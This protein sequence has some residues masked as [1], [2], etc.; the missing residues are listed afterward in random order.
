VKKNEKEHY[1]NNRDFSNAVVEHVT[2]VNEAIA[3]ESDIPR[4]TNYIATCFMKISE[5]LSH[6]SNFIRYSYRDEMVMD[7]VENCLKAIK[8]YNVEAA[9]RSGKPNAFAYFTQISW[10]AFLRRI[11]KE[12]RQ[13]DIKFKYIEMSGFDQF[14]TADENG[15]YDPA[16]IEEL[17]SA[18]ATYQ[19]QTDA[20]DKQPYVKHKIL[21][22]GKNL[23]KFMEPE[24]NGLDV[25]VAIVDEA[26]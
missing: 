25:D 26:E 22:Q 23:G 20:T 11:A 2:S 4:V 13:N 10:F 3:A 18:H 15:D 24:I 17:R 21:S 19:N 5:G 6:K 1:V 9:T 16:F 7:A 12:K 8:N 14:V